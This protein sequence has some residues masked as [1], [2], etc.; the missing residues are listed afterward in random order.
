MARKELAQPF[1]P[2]SS[3]AATGMTTT[4]GTGLANLSRPEPPRPGVEPL[5]A[6]EHSATAAILETPTRTLI[7]WVERKIVLP[8]IRDA[9]GSGSRRE[10]SEANLVELAITKEL[11]SLGVKRDI[12]RALMQ[13]GRAHAD[14]RA[15]FFTLAPAA[16]EEFLVIDLDAATWRVVEVRAGP[17]GQSLQ[18][19]LS[20]LGLCVKAAR[21]TVTLYFSALKAE[22]REKRARVT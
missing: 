13:F 9:A 12:V 2:L 18:N 11:L 10:Y 14:E 6:L 16:H 1:P 4:T 15:Q 3:P 20:L 5:G 22:L 21:R 7:D 8:D 17:A 19:D